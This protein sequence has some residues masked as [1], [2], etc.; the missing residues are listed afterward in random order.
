VVSLTAGALVGFLLFNA[1]T[2]WRARALVFMGDTGSLMLGLLLGWVAVRLAM[3]EPRGLAPITAVWI[4][5]LPIA[6][7]VTIMLRRAL[8]GHSPFHA[9]REHLHH[10]LL[11]SGLSSSRVVT[12]MVGC[13]ALLAA[14]GIAAPYA[15]VPEYALFSAYM[16]VLVAYGIGAELAC[17]KLGLRT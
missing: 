10:I 13:A 5:G 12:T 17:R 6:D 2:P 9:D 1:R 14:I 4:L 11:A 3:S 16:A 8:R 15:G 7:T